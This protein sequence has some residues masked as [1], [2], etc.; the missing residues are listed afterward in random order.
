MLNGSRTGACSEVLDRSNS[1]T[2]GL[3]A[4]S[5][6]HAGRVQALV[7]NILPQLFNADLL[8]ERHSHAVLQDVRVG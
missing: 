7:P 6:I 1:G 3:I 2:R 8:H 4:D 5:E